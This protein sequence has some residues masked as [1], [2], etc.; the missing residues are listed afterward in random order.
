V[1]PAAELLIGLSAV[2]LVRQPVSAV[3][4][5]R[6]GNAWLAGL[7]RDTLA[8]SAANR[9]T[10]G[11]LIRYREP[12]PVSAACAPIQAASGGTAGIVLILHELTLQRRLEAAASRADRLAALG[13]VA[14]GLAHEIR[15]P[16][17]GI[18]GAAQLLRGMLATPDQ[19]ACTDVIIREVDRLDL[20]VEQLR[21]LTPR[22]A[23]TMGPVNIHRVLTDVLAL[24][25]QSPDFGRIRL[26]TEFDPSLPPVHGAHAALTQV[27]LN[28]LRNAIQALAGEGELV[29]STRMETSLRVRRGG[30]LRQHLS[31]HVEDSGPGVPE[32]DQARL[33]TPFFT[34]R[35][36]GTG[37]G[38]AICHRIVTE[39][40]GT[41]VYADRR[42][43]GARFSVT[44][45]VHEDHVA[46]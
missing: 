26:R 3:F 39:H 41:I 19:I 20:L 18:K 27:F 16:L 42:T 43:G 28:L 8:E 35:A 5:E 32:A 2:H 44:L 22:P 21:D 15:K 11:T 1:N 38:L 17:G 23:T 12:L 46:G 10:E 31:I 37:L 24:Q 30:D 25:R 14:A 33:F 6:S 4:S 29:V 34:S 45:P 40:G 9:R 36:Q 7:V 13:P